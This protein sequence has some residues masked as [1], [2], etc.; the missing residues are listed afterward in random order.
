M[1]L[2]KLLSADEERIVRT[3]GSAAAITPAARQRRTIVLRMQDAVNWRTGE[4][5]IRI[6]AARWST[7]I[8]LF[9]QKGLHIDF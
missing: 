9:Q 5:S 2:S 6:T 8:Y 3:L 7:V 1:P 4:R